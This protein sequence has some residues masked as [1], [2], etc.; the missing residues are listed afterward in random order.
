MTK[1]LVYTKTMVS[2]GGH[3]ADHIGPLGDGLIMM[4][5]FH[6][7]FLR[8]CVPLSKKSL[9]SDL[10]HFCSMLVLDNGRYLFHHP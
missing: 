6:G 9:Y 3:Q 2:D 10:V 7:T 4:T 1:P 8:M 5:S